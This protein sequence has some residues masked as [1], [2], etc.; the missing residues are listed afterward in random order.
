[1]DYSLPYSISWSLGKYVLGYVMNQTGLYIGNNIIQNILVKTLIGNWMK[2]DDDYNQTIIIK[3]KLSEG[4]S[5]LIFSTLALIT[6]KRVYDLYRKKQ[7]NRSSINM[8]RLFTNKDNERLYIYFLFGIATYIFHQTGVRDIRAYIKNSNDSNIK[9]I[10]EQVEKDGSIKLI[11]VIEEASSDHNSVWN[12]YTFIIN[13]YYHSVPYYNSSHPKIVD[14]ITD[15]NIL[16]I[17]FNIFLGF[18]IRL[19][20]L[21][22]RHDKNNGEKSSNWMTLFLY[23]EMFF[24]LLKVHDMAPMYQIIKS[25]FKYLFPEYFSKLYIT[26]TDFNKKIN[27]WK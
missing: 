27:P 19:N 23:I 7:E 12:L 24:H 4:L 3:D 2:S 21:I 17:M 16:R 18:S 14:R 22:V 8:G 13:K 25:T 15:V 26:S 10:L 11:S 9:D 1:M 20:G 5:T 6:G